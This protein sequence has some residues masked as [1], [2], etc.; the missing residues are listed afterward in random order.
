MS[1]PNLTKKEIALA[2]YRKTGYPQKQIVDTIQQTLDFIQAALAAGRNAEFR[3]FGV[4]EVQVR[5]PRIGRNPN[6]PTE[7]VMIPLRA[8]VKFSGGKILRQ[9]LKKLDLSKLT[10]APAPKSES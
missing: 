8:V 9:Q 4:L 5:K 10:E 3:N 2:I 7:T 6:K 1:L